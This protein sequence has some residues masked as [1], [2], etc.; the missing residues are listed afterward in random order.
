[1]PRTI[2]MNTIP[3]HESKSSRMRSMRPKSQCRHCSRWFQPMLAGPLAHYC[4]RVECR[5]A[6]KRDWSVRYRRRIKEGHTPREQA[7]RRLE[8]V[9]APAP[10]PKP[11]TWWV[12]QA[13]GVM[14]RCVKCDGP[15][16][17]VYVAPT[18]G[19]QGECAVVA[20]CRMCGAERMVLAGRGGV[21]YEDQTRGVIRGPR[22]VARRMNTSR[23]AR[24]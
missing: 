2:I 23:R 12:A 8:I 1:M 22:E 9:R 7:P 17:G 15:V 14:E 19:T 6:M 11:V 24:A 21:P 20:H 4:Y 3:S 5:V 16:E 10:P 18:Q 13:M